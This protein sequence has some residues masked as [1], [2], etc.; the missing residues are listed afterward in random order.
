MYSS[1]MRKAYNQTEAQTNIHPV[2]LIHLLYERALTHLEFAR[3]AIKDGNPKKRGENIGKTIAIIT[4]L[5]ASVDEK[6]ESEAA[7]IL[8]G[9]YGAILVELPKVALEGDLNILRRAYNYIAKLKEIWEQTAMQEEG[10]SSDKEKPGL[11][12]QE[13]AVKQQ[14]VSSEKQTYGPTST[15]FRKEISALSVSI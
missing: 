12:K 1:R 13:V 9:L 2:K 3:D 8:R 15:E 6:D 10:F 4:E 5:N 14:D 7:G 11:K